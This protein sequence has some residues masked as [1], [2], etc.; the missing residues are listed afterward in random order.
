MFRYN[1][2]LFLTCPTVSPL[3]RAFQWV[4]K[5]GGVGLMR[6][7]CGVF[8]FLKS[9][10]HHLGSVASTDSSRAGSV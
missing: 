2:N 6:V 10:P 8:S 5:I 9:K 1:V 3:Q 7:L 4:C